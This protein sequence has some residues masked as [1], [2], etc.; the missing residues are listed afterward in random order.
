M[1]PYIMQVNSFVKIFN[2][3]VHPRDQLFEDRNEKLLQAVETVNREIPATD[4]L[5][6]G[7]TAETV[8]CVLPIVEAVYDMPDLRPESGSERW[9]EYM[10]KHIQQAT[11][12]DL[13]SFP[14]LLKQF[15][16]KMEK[17]GTDKVCVCF[18][19]I[20]CV[21]PY[22]NMIVSLYF[23]ACVLMLICVSPYTHM[24]V[25]LCQYAC[26]LIH[27]CLCPYAIMRMPLCLIYNC[28]L[29]PIC[30][31]PYTYILM[32]LCYCAYVLMLLCVCH[33]LGQKDD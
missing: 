17:K 14:Q 21:C 10:K 27:A 25:S 19:M 8:K 7:D 30:L 26:V 3:L 1:C 11:F 20:L 24:I 22:A 33:T 2:D 5:N 32:S 18:L 15:V 12:H 16:K 6:N 31:C 29:M 9:I 28:V 23:Y 13:V 4:L